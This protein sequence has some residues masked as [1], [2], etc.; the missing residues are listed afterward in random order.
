MAQFFCG[1]EGEKAWHP[2]C[3]PNSTALLPEFDLSIP[4]QLGRRT[5]N[6][7]PTDAGLLSAMDNSF[8]GAC[9]PKQASSD[10]GRPGR[11]STETDR[12]DRS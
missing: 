2:R 5:A 10:R 12:T 1:L 11:A 7:A 6:S 4:S 9:R 8:N 3:A